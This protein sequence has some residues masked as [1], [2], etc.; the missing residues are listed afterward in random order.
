MNKREAILPDEIIFGPV[1]SRLL[2]NS[3]GINLLPQASKLCNMNCIYCECGW[4]HTKSTKNFKFHGAGDVIS[5][6][7][8]KLKSLKG[9]GKMPDVITFVGNGEPTLH[10]EF[11]EII[12]QALVVRNTYAPRT[13]VAVLSNAMNLSKPGVTKALM[14]ADLCILKM[15]AGTN[16]MFQRINQPHSEKKLEKIVKQLS[17]FR[18]NLIIQSLFLK[19]TIQG[20]PL[21]NSD[22]ENLSAW[23]ERLKAVRPSRVFVY[24]L[25][26]AIPAQGLEKI[27]KQRLNEIARRV[28][29][30]NIRALVS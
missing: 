24:T 11:D 7:K 22:E 14:K 6:L 4:T 16:Q 15:D 2:G 25:N 17:L 20:D 23:I 27:P 18:G 10:P 3:L 21:D 1:K 13:K 26:H 28:R 19:G 8:R 12:A 29:V 9:E 30:L 5:N